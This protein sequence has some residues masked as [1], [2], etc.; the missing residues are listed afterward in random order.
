MMFSGPVRIA[1][2]LISCQLGYSQTAPLPA[3]VGYRR[4][5]TTLIVAPGQMVTISVFGVAGRFANPVLPPAG[6]N[7]FPLEVEGLRLELSQGT[8]RAS[9]PISYLQQSAC[10]PSSVCNP[11]TTLTTLFP[12][13]MRVDADAATT[14]RVTERGAAVAE[15]KLEVLSDQIHMI[16]TC[17][18]TGQSIGLAIDLPVGACVPMVINANDIRPVIASRPAKAGDTLLIWAYGLGILNAE[19]RTEVPVTLNLSYRRAGTSSWMRGPALVPTFAGGQVGGGSSI[20][21]QL[22]FVVPTAPEGIA[23][24]TETRGNLRILASGPSSSDVAEICVR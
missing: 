23:T 19:A 14:L 4:P 16:N 9:L 15:L 11:V 12:D 22:H 20:L 13:E 18:Q 5:G 3:F 8:L 7:G 1:L 10:Q 24:C 2:L 17:D 6:I 21:Y